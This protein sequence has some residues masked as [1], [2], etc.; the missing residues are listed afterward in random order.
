MEIFWGFASYILAHWELILVCSLSVAALGYAAFILKN[1]K[2]A[3][4]AVVIACCGLAYQGADMAGY[5]RKVA[6]DVAA[7]TEI[8][9]NRLT[10]LN[11]LALKNAAQ[12]KVDADK[13]NEL[14]SKASET[15]KNDGACLDA[16][17]ASRVRNIR[18]GKPVATGTVRHT[19]VL[20]QGSR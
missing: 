4:A 8:Y 6:E 12:A 3:I 18:S 9:K 19:N 7:Q 14:E 1:W 15:P 20:P 10:A 16:A 17:A 2:V 13:I 11:N 5:N